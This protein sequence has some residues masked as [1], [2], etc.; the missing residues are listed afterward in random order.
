[1][2]TGEPAAIVTGVSRGLGAALAA[3]LLERGFAVL[4]VGRRDGA[5]SDGRY[6]FAELD[7]AR[8]A[9]IDAAL[10]PVFEALREGRPSSVCLVN[11]AA[12]IEPAGTIGR[13]TAPEIASAVAVNLA[14]PAALASLFCRVFSD[15]ALPRRVINVSSG[16]AERPIEGEAL[17]SAAKAGLEMLTRALAAEQRAPT[18]RAVTVRPGV[19]DTEMQTYARTRSPDVLPSVG[20]FEGFH[21]EGRLVP[22]DVVAAKIV[23]RLVLRDVEHGRTYAYPDL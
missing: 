10:A 4:G 19:I 17:Y 5:F 9:G 16:A 11:N 20:M 18:F 21:R 3:E 23:D 2:A 1:M 12:T 7:L 14:A 6:Q 22:A 13:P 15:D 8:P